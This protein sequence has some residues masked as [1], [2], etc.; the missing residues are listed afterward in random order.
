MKIPVRIFVDASKSSGLI[1]S[2]YSYPRRQSWIA[3]GTCTRVFSVKPFMRKLYHYSPL[4][5]RLS[6]K[7]VVRTHGLVFKTHIQPNGLVQLIDDNLVLARGHLALPFMH[8]LYQTS[9]PCAHLKRQLLDLLKPG[10]LGGDAADQGAANAVL[11]MR[12][13]S[14]PD[15]ICQQAKG[16]GGFAA[17]KR[18]PRRCAPTKPTGSDLIATVNCHSRFFLS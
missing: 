13:I 5:R 8:I 16:G 12:E 14:P 11:S 4:P 1:L 10:C 17:G 18:A 15:W 3:A 2:R 9:C 6:R 7:F